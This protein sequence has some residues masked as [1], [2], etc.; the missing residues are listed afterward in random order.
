MPVLDINRKYLRYRK[1]KIISLDH[2][3][4]FFIKLCL[5]KILLRILSKICTHSPCIPKPELTTKYLNNIFFIF[6][7]NVRSMEVLGCTFKKIQHFVQK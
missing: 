5:N 2:S 6:Y 7:K 3:S 4:F 1:Y